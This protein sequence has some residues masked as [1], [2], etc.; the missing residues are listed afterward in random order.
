[1]FYYKLTSKKRGDIHRDSINDYAKSLGLEGIAMISVD[2]DMS[3]LRL[4]VI[5]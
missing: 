5:T 4:K 3:A 1:V 2:E